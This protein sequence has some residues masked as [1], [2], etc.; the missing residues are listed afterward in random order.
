MLG[1]ADLREDDAEGHRPLLGKADGKK[2]TQLKCAQRAIS[3]D[4]SCRNTI[5]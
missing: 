2:S 5:G 4:T 3:G 1:L